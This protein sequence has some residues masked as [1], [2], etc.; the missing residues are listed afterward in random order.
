L[1]LE[2]CVDCGLGAVLAIAAG[3]SDR[4]DYLAIEHD[5]KRAGL[6]EI[7]YECGGEIYRRFEP[8]CWFPKSD[9]AIAAC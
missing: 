9:A 6:W 2:D 5:W 3:N 4:A 7:I 8:S 1:S